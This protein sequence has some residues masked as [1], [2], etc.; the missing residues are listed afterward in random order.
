MTLCT[1]I[2]ARMGSTRLP[3]KVLLKVGAKTVLEHV[4]DRVRM[5]PADTGTLVIAVPA[6]SDNDPI[7][8]LCGR[9]GTICYRSSEQDVLHRYQQ[10][11]ICYGATDVLRVTADMPLLCPQLT[12]SILRYAGPYDYVT[13]QDV[14]LGLAAERI[15]AEALYRCW[16]E[17]TN[18]YEREH[19][20]LHATNHPK[21]FRLRYLE[22]ED[23][24]FDRR[25][26]RL[27][28]DTREDMELLER[29]YELTDG[30]LFQL[31]TQAIL[32]AVD[33]DRHTLELAT[34][35]L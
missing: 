25:T 4:I 33:A 15:T 2:Q 16:A 22:P 31:G 35:R 29:L 19:V 12:D 5:C 13:Y 28:L 9:L 10:A 8:D 30:A 26:W 3:G 27:T 20:T 11:S 24:L 23:W 21:L 14:P 18:P 32:E 17:A 34:R 6:N 7:A 1:I